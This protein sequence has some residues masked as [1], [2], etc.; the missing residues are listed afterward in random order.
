[1]RQSAAIEQNIL[2]RGAESAGWRATP[3]ED[4]HYMYAIAL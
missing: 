2:S 3:D 4:E 1:M